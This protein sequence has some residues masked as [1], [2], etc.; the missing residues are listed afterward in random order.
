MPDADVVGLPGEEL[1]AG[2]AQ[3]DGE[4]QEIPSVFSITNR[5]LVGRAE[6][7]PAAKDGSRVI[8]L[9]SGNGGTII[10]AN[11]S[12]QISQFVGLKLLEV[13]VIAAEDEEEA[14]DAAA[15]AD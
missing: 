11:L 1:V 9:F 4:P 15:S 6:V 13:E 2:A 8:R 12:P 7:S 3:E 10:E 14:P 5:H